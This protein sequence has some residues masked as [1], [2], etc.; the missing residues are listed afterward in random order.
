MGIF[1]F[2]D[3]FTDDSFDST[4]DNYIGSDLFVDDTFHSMDCIH[5]NEINPATGLS[6]MGCIDVAGNPYGTDLNSTIDS[7][8]DSYSSSTSGIDDT[9]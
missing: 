5:D 1:D 7:G 2:F 3:L 9:F 4:T 6:M 8:I